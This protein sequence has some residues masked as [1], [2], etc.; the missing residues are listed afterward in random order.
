MPRGRDTSAGDPG[1][2]A[3]TEP[4][5]AW[6]SCLIPHTR[7]SVHVGWFGPWGTVK[8]RSQE[9]LAA[10]HTTR[11]GCHVAPRVDELPL[12]VARESI[13]ALMVRGPGAAQRRGTNARLSGQRVRTSAQDWARQSQQTAMRN[14]CPRQAQPM[15]VRCV[16]SYAQYGSRF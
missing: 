4:H 11:L 13:V 2:S 15:A 10:F 6:E 8:G 1:S 14:R 7:P 5:C 12:L 3:S 16:V 9:V